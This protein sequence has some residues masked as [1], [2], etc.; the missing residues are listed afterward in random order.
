MRVQDLMNVLSMMNP[1]E[2]VLIKDKD[3]NIIPLKDVV[4][5]R[6]QYKAEDL[7][8]NLDS[9]GE[10]AIYLGEKDEV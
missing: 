6:Y 7:C 4:E 8:Y 9:S 10:L 2:V 5:V 3:D 1:K